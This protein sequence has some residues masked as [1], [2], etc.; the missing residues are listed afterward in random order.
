MSLGG[1]QYYEY[2]DTFSLKGAIDN[3]RTAGIAT[4]IASG[5]NYW[6]G[7]MAAP[8]CI[9]S[10]ISVGATVSSDSDAVSDYSNSATFL[11]L[12]APGSTISSSIPGVGYSDKDGT[13]MAAP[14]VAGSWALMKQ[15]YPAAT[16]D[17]I[18]DSL[19]STGPSINDTKCTQMTKKRINVNDA[20]TRMSSSAS[21]ALSKTGVGTGTV[22]SVPPGIDCGEDCGGLFPKGVPVRLI[23]T[24]D[25]GTEFG[26]WSGG[27]CSGT[28]E[29]TIT[30]TATTSVDALFLKQVTV[31]SDIAITGFDFGDKKGK[32]F[33]GEVAAK[34]TSWTDTLIT[35]TV[36][37]VPLPAGIYHASI[38]SKAMGT[39]NI[40]NA[41]TVKNP[42]L[43]PL[44]D[45]S[46]KY[47]DEIT[48][49]GN[50]FGIKKGKVYLE[51]KDSNGQTKKKNCK[52][53]Y[54][55]MNPT[56]G[57]SELKFFVPKLSN[58]FPA[59]AYPLKVDN[60]IGIATADTDFTIL[61]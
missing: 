37:K 48:I 21:L 38:T 20:Y 11:S 45:S 41:F 49:Y 60:K 47:P 6:C 54:W 25:P 22:T 51:Y 35:G 42:E 19:R 61:P 4:V 5:N 13:S 59:S 17:E 29:C 10:A 31:G 23:A 27:G 2:C 39:K 28:G 50:F 30:I 58:S 32:V 55:Y 36:K 43:D 15:V 44:L 40:D 14:H 33:I 46:G 1:G 53:T 24:A 12:L 8:A 34:I 52:V 9:S 16:V 7:S 3:L 57:A 26:G 56:T 18:L